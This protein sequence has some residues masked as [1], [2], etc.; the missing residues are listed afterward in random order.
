MVYKADEILLLLSAEQLRLQPSNCSIL[1]TGLQGMQVS[2]TGGAAEIMRVMTMLH[3]IQLLPDIN[4][5][6]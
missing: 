4:G 2:I 6:T 1:T 3:D 5:I